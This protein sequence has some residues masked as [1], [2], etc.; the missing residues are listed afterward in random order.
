MSTP[1]IHFYDQHVA[2]SNFLEEV[3]LGLSTRPKSIAP[4]FFYDAAGSALFDRICEL[5][6]YYLT[7]VETD[8]LKTHASD[9]AGLSG[10][11]CLLV[12]FG[13]GS[14]A[15]V[16]LLLEALQ[17]TAYLPID[18]SRDYLRET[19]HALAADYPW[20]TVHATCA[21][22]S[23]GLTLPFSP[24]GAR[25]VGFFPGSSIGNFDPSDALA[26][27][28]SAA[29]MLGDNGAMIVGVDLKKDPQVLHA[30]YND[31]A[32]VTR[33]FNLNLLRR[34][35]R[36]LDGDFQLADFHH[37]AFY[38]PQQS[39]IE[40]H[41]VSTRRQTVRIGGRSF[42]FAAGESL[43]TENSYKYSLDEFRQLATAA[44]FVCRH[45]WTDAQERFAVVFL[46]CRGR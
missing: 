38:H 1:T 18:I 42:D 44:G 37:Y 3:W 17:P 33:E 8:I 20:L 2:P 7:R 41:L 43:H 26:F 35:N 27:L 5:P 30:A 15:K 12:E 28:K 36:E 39:R 32:G 6:E 22:Y 19:A 13:S 29:T 31:A 24:Q 40:M 21:D 23:H 16:R 25:K 11:D 34:I 46:E 45:R 10:E 4:K 14:S 9:I